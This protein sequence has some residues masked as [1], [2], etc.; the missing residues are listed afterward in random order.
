[1]PISVE[2]VRFRHGRRDF[3]D[4]MWRVWPTKPDRK[5]LSNG[6]YADGIAF[7]YYRVV[8]GKA[9]HGVFHLVRK[10]NNLLR[11]KFMCADTS[12]PPVTAEYEGLPA[13]PADPDGF[14]TAN[15]EL[16]RYRSEEEVLP[17]GWMLLRPEGLPPSF[18]PPG[19]VEGTRNRHHPRRVQTAMRRCLQDGRSPGGHP[20]KHLD[21]ASALLAFQRERG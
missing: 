8:R 20:L 21:S 10:D 12:V 11:G 13:S 19:A 15:L 1:M 5:W 14:W 3:K 2:L 17:I 7:G 18:L 9:T 6:R 4:T 16:I